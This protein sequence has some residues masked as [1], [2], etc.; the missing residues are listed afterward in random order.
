VGFPL[1]GAKLNG[2]YQAILEKMWRRNVMN[3]EIDPDGVGEVDPASGICDLIE[4]AFKS[5]G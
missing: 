1:T 4:K 2:V 5:N 3:V